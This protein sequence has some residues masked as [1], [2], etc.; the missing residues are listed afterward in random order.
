MRVQSLTFSRHGG[1]REGC[2]PAVGRGGEAL[3]Q[4]AN[5]PSTP[6][7]LPRSTRWGRSRTRKGLKKGYWLSTRSLPALKGFCSTSERRRQAICARAE[8]K[9]V[10]PRRPE[11]SLPARRGPRRQGPP[12]NAGQLPQN[13]GQL[14]Q[15]HAQGAKRHQE[16]LEEVVLR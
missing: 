3:P 9:F 5:S 14:A 13:A 6:A 1:R 10:A 11:G 4:N 7:K 12:Q 8:S 2:R 16:G 15:K